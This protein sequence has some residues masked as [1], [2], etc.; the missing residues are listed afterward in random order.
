MT[1]P[2]GVLI[3]ALALLLGA[4][5]GD[6]ASS[7]P[8]EQLPA[9]GGVRERV[10]DAQQVSKSDFPSAKGRSLAEISQELGARPGEAALASS[11][12]VS[13]RA[14]RLA[15]GQIT[16]DGQFAY[17]KSAIYVSRTPNKTAQGPF[18]APADILMTEPA[19]RSR[20]AAT[21]EDPFAAI[22]AAAVPF[23]EPGT[24]GIVTV[25]RD[26]AE[27]VAAT[28]QV[29]VRTPSQDTVPDVGEPAPK[30]ETDTV[31]AAAG[32]LEAIDT[33]VPPSDMHESSLANVLGKK[34]VALLFA[35]PQ[36]CQSRV[37]GPVVDVGLQLKERY[38]DEVEFIHQE[39]Y[40]NN[41]PN[42]GL[43]E[44]LQRFRLPSEPWLFAIDRDGRITTR[45]EGSFGL[46]AFE[47]A[48]KSAL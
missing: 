43:R 28:G 18:P 35:T 7:D 48:V 24:Y 30:V 36:L 39:V 13:G 25:T 4:C 45:L 2:L 5:G 19:F 11:V 33:R 6:D 3:A 10:A 17:G 12:F 38:G 15:F 37:C 20:Q 42:Q 14:N 44:P 1:R 22:Y 40:A 32:D 21:E 27:T 16:A 9:S 29:Q 34:P 46:R 47:D 26:G 41:D 23:K 8:V 31:A